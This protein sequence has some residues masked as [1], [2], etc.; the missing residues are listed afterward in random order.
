MIIPC[1]G[2][3]PI[4]MQAEF[5]PVPAAVLPLGSEIVLEKILK[6]TITHYDQILV[7]FAEDFPLVESI[8]RKISSKVKLVKVGHTFSLAETI[9]KAALHLLPEVSLLTIQM[10]DAFHDKAGPFEDSLSVCEDIVNSRWVTVSFNKDKRIEQFQLPGAEK[11]ASKDLVFAGKFTVSDPKEF[12]RR[13]NDSRENGNWRAGSL[14]DAL[15]SYFNVRGPAPLSE[16]T[17][18]HDFGYLSSYYHFR[19]ISGF[20]ERK[21][22]SLEIDLDRNSITKRSANRAK[23]IDEINWYQKMPAELAY[24][25]PRIFQSQTGDAPWVEMEYLAGIPLD[26]LLLFSRTSLQTWKRILRHL[27]LAIRRFRENGRAS[28]L[29]P[30]VAGEQMY[31]HK[32]MERMAKFVSE[33]RFRSLRS[34]PFK[35]NGKTVPNLI[36]AQSTISKWVQD[37]NFQKGFIPSIIHGDL[38]FS[39][40]VYDSRLDKINLVDPRGSFG[41]PGIYGDLRYDLAKLQHSALGRY[42]FLVNGHFK[43]KQNGSDYVIDEIIDQRQMEIGALVGNFVKSQAGKDLWQICFIESLLFLSMIPLHMDKPESQMAFALRGLET[44]QRAIELRA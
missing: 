43:L 36:E 3:L 26:Q 2:G 8:C 28:P 6:E 7:A 24:L 42:D 16:N 41:S 44:L 30:R 13:L 19:R 22:N 18:W 38:C 14:Y 12:L 32:T 35:V 17:D 27:D 20:N 31:G 34:G 21:F 15:S 37:V 39:N 1:A 5:G 33:E 29:D 10:G 40:V 23:F 4:D 9:S 11:V 25:T